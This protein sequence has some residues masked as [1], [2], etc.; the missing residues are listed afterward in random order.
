MEESQAKLQAKLAELEK[1]GGSGDS[2]A[3]EDD[4]EPAPMEESVE[5]PAADAAPAEPEPTKEAESPAESAP[6]EEAKGDKCMC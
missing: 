6:S 1:S 2:A 5:T 3:K 4:K